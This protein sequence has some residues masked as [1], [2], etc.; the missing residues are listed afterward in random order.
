MHE[1]SIPAYFADF[2][3]I[4]MPQS[5]PSSAFQPDHLTNV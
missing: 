4:A 1:Q 3:H 5:R 2:S